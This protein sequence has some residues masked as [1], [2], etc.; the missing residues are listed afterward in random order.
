MFARKVHDLRH[1]GL[2]YLVSIHATL[3]DPVVV[4]MQHN[5]CGGFMILAEEPLKHMHNEFHRRVVIVENEHAIHVRALRLGLGLGNNRRARTALFIPTF[6]IIVGHAW[7]ICARQSHACRTVLPD[8]GRHSKAETVDSRMLHL[9]IIK[10]RAQ[11]FQVG[12]SLKP[13]PFRDN[14]Q[15]VRDFAPETQITIA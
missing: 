5:S 11:L 6:T 4:H 8:Q 2:S 3:A 9:G 12:N 7:R 15:N 1:L 14:E 10:T 13:A